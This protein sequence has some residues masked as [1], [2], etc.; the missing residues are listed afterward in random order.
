M[1]KRQKLLERFLKTPPPLDLRFDELDT[2]LRSFGFR[3]HENSGGSSHKLFVRTE[4]DGRE[5]RIVCS[6]PHPG[7]VL[8]AYQI[9]EIRD[10]LI[11]WGF[12]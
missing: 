12:L 3:M 5:H 9:R 6:R 11:Q 4:A 10:R 8:K 2:L 1:S 7:G